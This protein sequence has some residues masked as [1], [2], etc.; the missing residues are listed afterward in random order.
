MFFFFT[1]LL[2]FVDY[3]R[4][5]FLDMSAVCVALSGNFLSGLNILCFLGC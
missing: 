4:F 1:S 3:R 2:R 5:F